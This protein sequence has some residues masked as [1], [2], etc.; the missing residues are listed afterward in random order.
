MTNRSKHMRYRLRNHEIKQPLCSSRECYIHSSQSCSWDLRYDDPT[1]WTP[2]ELEES[3]E[4][5][6]TC[7]CEVTDGWY[8]G[9]FDGWVEADI[10]TDYEHGATLSNGGPE[11]G[12]AAAER[13]GCEEEEGG[14]GYHFDDAVDTGCEEA[15]AGALG[16]RSMGDDR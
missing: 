2:T 14:A 16:G 10:E 15:G 9:S 13:V 12:S 8:G 3:S 1:T 11:K 4:E 7:Q 5:K 6:D